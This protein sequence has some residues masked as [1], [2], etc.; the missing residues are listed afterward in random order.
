MIQIEE[1]R[2][3]EAMRWAAG[4]R[5]TAK[6][7]LIGA[8]VGWSV[9]VRYVIDSGFLLQN[10]LPEEDRLTLVV[11]IMGG[12]ALALLLVALA[13]AR[14]RWQAVPTLERCVTACAP[15]AVLAFL[16]VLLVPEVWYSKPLPCLT[17]LAVLVLLLERL[18]VAWLRELSPSAAAL[19]GLPSFRIPAELRRAL[20]F[21]IVFA[22]A[23]G[24]SCY[25][26]YFSLQQHQRLQTAAYDLGIYDNLMYTAM[27]G[28]PFRSTV[29]L[30]P[31]GGSYLVGHAEF[32]MLLFLPLYALWSS[33]EMLLTLQAV[34]LGFAAVPL[35]LFAR[36]QLTRR[37]AVVIAL[38]Y[39]LYAPMHGSSF[40]DFHWLPLTMFFQFSLYYAI[41]KN[42]SW[43][44]ALSYAVLVLM[45]EDV[46]VGLTV[47]GTFL[48]VSGI[49][50]KLGLA[51][52]V[53]S[54]IAFVTIKF[55]IMVWAGP[56][57]FADLYYKKLVAPGE[58]GFGSVIK[59]LLTNPMYVVETVLD[60]HKLNYFL[61]LMAP[62]A[63]I[64]LRHPLL[65]LLICAG[66]LFTFLTTAYDPTVSISFQY[67]AH[68]IPYLFAA[69]VLMLGMLSRQP[70]GSI[71]R[72]AA[73]GAL[74]FGVAV[75]SYV[76]GAV[77]QHDT[78][79]GG[80]LR[81]PFQINQTER[82]TYAALNRVIAH[83]PADA[84]VAATDMEVAH[85]S[86]RFTIYTLR[87]HHGNADYLLINKAGVSG[88]TRNVLKDALRK[89]DY[90]LVASELPF[91]L[92]AKGVVSPRTDKALQLMGLR[93]ARDSNPN[94]KSGEPQ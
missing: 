67:S 72:R 38:A 33:A 94:A 8:I 82:V 28:Y 56:F 16:P 47:L 35:Y 88:N 55:G 61:H 31:D 46:S 59:T 69:V 34:L 32:A 29:L 89:N 70:D 14:S 58:Q 19:F 71:R 90:G 22:G 10:A 26:L 62:L 68:W 3:L 57:Y 27:S 53:S 86:N 52:A 7:A 9:A 92:F 6:L 73:L 41:A 64:P 30:G 36:T 51:M 83:I 75:H 12:G 15:L 44:I 48:L 24:Y 66:T 63:F 85:V 42:R 87:A 78:Y 23:A 93:A 25:S 50:P 74:V 54:A 11:G 40:Y 77:L 4:A 76:F 1:I 65:L 79:V 84:S 5:A 81:V 20:P 13:F 17:V 91:Y 60:P 37:S 21:A 43:L 80:F 2:P 45:R 18:L 39:L 49:R